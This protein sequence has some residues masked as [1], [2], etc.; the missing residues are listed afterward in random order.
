MRGQRRILVHDR[1]RGR[2]TGQS[3]PTRDPVL[4]A[5]QKKID[6]MQEHFDVGEGHP[7]R[8]SMTS[9]PLA[10]DVELAPV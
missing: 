2:S 3:D 6:E 4:A 1:I 10:Y 8:N 7:K 9:E 5:M